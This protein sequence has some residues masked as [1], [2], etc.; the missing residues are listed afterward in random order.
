MVETWVLGNMARSIAQG[1]LATDIDE[2]DRCYREEDAK[3]ATHSLNG[4][5]GILA[6][7]AESNVEPPSRLDFYRFR[8]HAR[9]AK[10]YEQQG[11]LSEVSNHTHQAE[12]LGRQLGLL[13]SG[14]AS[15]GVLDVLKRLDSA[16]HHRAT[17]P[18]DGPTK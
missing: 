18:S 7:A 12:I 1:H 9:L 8:T 16:D 10:L 13:Q 11:D 2:V 6:D 5:L 14:K 3:V 4:L 15:S 17:S